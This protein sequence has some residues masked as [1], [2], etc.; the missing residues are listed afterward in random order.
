MGTL[1]ITQATTTL[2]WATPAAITYGTPLSATQLDATS[3]GVAGTFVYTPAAGTVLPAG[4]QLLSVTFTPTDGADYSAAS[5]TVTLTVNKAPLTVTPNPASKVYGT[6]NPAFTGSITGLVAG[7]TIT[8]TYASG[9]TT[10]TAVGVYSSGVDAIAATLSDPGN[11]LGN[12]TLTQNLGTLTITQ[13]TTTSLGPIRRRSRMERLSAR[14]SLTLR[15]AAWPA[16]SFTRQQRARYWLLVRK[17]CPSPSRQ[18]ITADYSSQTATVSLTVNKAPL[19][20]TPNNVSRL[21]GVANPAFTGS[22]TGLVAG[23]T[24]TATYASAANLTTVVG[25][26]SSGPNAIAATL[27]DPGS[28]LGNYTLTQNLGTLTITQTTTTLTWAN[29]A[30]ITYGTALSAAQLNATSG[31]VAGTFVYTPPAGTMLPVGV[32]TL[33]VVF[34]PTDGRLQRRHGNRFADRQ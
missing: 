6:A 25:V 19:T 18:P 17:R 30:A 21:Y 9:A 20:V 27:S 32:Q 26:Y 7:D 34:T 11:K 14:R 16:L 24:I 5:A 12:Y 29:P 33:S 13:A 3:G 23:D 15:L 22:I 28:K 2:T 31:G 4:S 8:A 1:T 10:T